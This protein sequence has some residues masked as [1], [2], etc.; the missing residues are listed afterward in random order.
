MKDSTYASGVIY[1]QQ[2][3]IRLGIAM[4]KDQSELRRVQLFADLPRAA[5]SKLEAVAKPVAYDDGQLIVLEGD[6]DAPVFFVVE[7]TVRAFRT[8][9]DGREQTLIYLETGAAFN[10]PVA[11]SEDHAAPA[12]AVATGPVRLLVVAHRDFRRVASETPEVALTVLR[13]FADKLRYFADLTHDLS[14]RSV[15][16][17]LARFLLLQS[18]AQD[19]PAVRW[20]QEE[21]AAQIGT[22]REVVS[23]TLRALVKEGLVKIERGRI[24]VLDPEALEAEAEV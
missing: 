17:R 6:A 19:A 21:I 14:L 4:K 13:D 15:R 1:R 12:S 11:F 16:G 23:R 18:Q 10:M 5:L 8:N 3:L 9:P 2:R 22:V 24:T 20:T 7:G